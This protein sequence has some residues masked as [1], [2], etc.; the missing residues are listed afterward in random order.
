MKNLIVILTLVFG[1]LLLAPSSA[2]A[3][4]A[5]SRGFHSSHGRVVVVHPG[6]RRVYHRRVIIVHSH[7]RYHHRRHFV[8]VR[9]HHHH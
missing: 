9:H 4:P 1:A 2:Q 5:R 6:H 8:V 7:H 3:S